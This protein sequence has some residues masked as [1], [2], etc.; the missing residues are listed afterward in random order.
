MTGVVNDGFLVISTG[1]NIW[2]TRKAIDFWR[3]T[4]GGGSAK[5]LFWASIWHLPLVMVGALVCK[6]G[7]WQGVWDKTVSD[8]LD[9][10]IAEEVLEDGHV[11]GDMVV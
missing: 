2:L 6:T 7:I 3:K 4:G 1:A 9:D 11:E 10:D 8:E 5:G